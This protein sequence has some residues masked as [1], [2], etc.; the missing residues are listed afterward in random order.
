[1]N[2]SMTRYGACAVSESAGLNRARTI[3]LRDGPPCRG[4]AG[5]PRMAL[6]ASLIEAVIYDGGA[7][8]AILPLGLRTVPLVG[9]LTMLPVTDEVAGRLDQAATGDPRISAGWILRQ[10]VAAL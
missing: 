6:M 4:T 3:V 1:M 2:E 8:P 5:C 9:G 10:P 7:R